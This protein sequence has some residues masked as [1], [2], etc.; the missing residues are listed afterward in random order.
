MY[1]HARKLV[2]LRQAEP[3]DSSSDLVTALLEARLNGEVMDPEAVAGT[4]RLVYIAG[5]IAPKTAIGSCMLFLS[6]HLDIQSELRARPELVSQAV[7]EL[8]RLETPN[9][10]FARQATRDVMVDG[11]LIHAGERVALVFTSG[12]RDAA[13]FEDPE[14]FRL[15]RDRVANR[16]LAF[17][18]GAHKCPG[19]ALSRLEMRV[20]LEELLVA[21]SEFSL[22]GEPE[23]SGWALH[24]PTRLPLALRARQ[25]TASR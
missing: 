6:Q 8:L 20:A 17:G 10:G 7:E 13:V 9:A 15:D 1:Q 3:L 22:S 14:V 5:H 24:G 19:A 2:A 11:Q 12:D 23:V 4:L 25:R 21:T 18:H 16:H